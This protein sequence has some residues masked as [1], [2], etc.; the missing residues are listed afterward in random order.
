MK[1][2]RFHLLGLA[3]LTTNRKNSACAYTQKVVKLA[4]MLKKN[5]HTLYFYGVEGSEVACDEFVKVSTQALLRDTY[6]DYNQNKEFFK[7]DPGD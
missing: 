5:G 2:L 7:H 1:K 3:H 4:E 6:L